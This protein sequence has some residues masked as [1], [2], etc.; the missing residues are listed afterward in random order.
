MA[1]REIALLLTGVGWRLALPIVL[2]TIGGAWLDR[3]L[4]TRPWFS[5]GGLVLGTV[6][7]F[8]SVYRLLLPIIKEATGNQGKG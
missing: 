2:A 6:V 7:G 5:L 1:S 4:D 3:R 8:Y